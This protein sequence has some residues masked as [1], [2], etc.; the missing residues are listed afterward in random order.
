M[1]IIVC[2]KYNASV[3]IVYFY[4]GIYPWHRE[5]ICCADNTTQK[6]KVRANIKI[7]IPLISL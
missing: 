2:I 5:D 6:I 4:I 7:K 3:Y 1:A